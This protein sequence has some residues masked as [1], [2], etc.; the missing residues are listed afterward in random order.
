[1]AKRRP[2]RRRRNR[3][4]RQPVQQT[5]RKR[6]RIIRWVK[7]LSGRLISRELVQFFQ[8]LFSQPN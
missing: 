6:H 4:R 5:N 2:K 7:E 3:K 8:D 1:M